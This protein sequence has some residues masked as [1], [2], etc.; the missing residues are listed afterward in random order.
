M[1]GQALMFTMTGAA[2]F[3]IGLSTSQTVFTVLGIAFLAVGL[4]VK[5]KKK[6]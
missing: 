6:E 2:F 1:T 5:R 4:S 3:A